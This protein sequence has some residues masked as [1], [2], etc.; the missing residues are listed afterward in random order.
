MLAKTLVSSLAM[1]AV[2]ACTDTGSS[3]DSL[4]RIDSEIAI[5]PRG[6]TCAQLGLGNQSLTLTNPVTGTYALDAQNSLNFTYYDDTNTIF[7]F[8]N[9]TIR[10]TGVLASIGDRTLMWELGVPGADG[11]GSLH[12]PPDADTGEIDTPEEVSFCFD[13]ELYVQPS[14]FAKHA[15]RNTWTITKSG[16]TERLVLAQGQEELVEYA[17]T[18]R[19]GESIEDGQ[20]I[21]GPMFVQ[22]K[23]PNTVTVGSVSVMVGTIAAGVTCPTAAPFT[24]AP[25]TIVE[26]AFRADVP[27]TT[28]RNVVGSA[29]V[30]HGLRVSTQEVVASFSSPTTGVD[31]VDHCVDVFD[32]AV[33]YADHYLGTVC[34]DTGEE[35]FEYSIEVGPYTTCGPFQVTNTASYV[36]LDTGATADAAWTIDGNV[37]CNAACTLTQRYWKVHSN[38]GHRRFNPTWNRI[39]AQGENTTFFH[40]GGTY[41]QAMYRFALGNPYWT[42]SKAYIAA[43]LNQLNGATFTPATQTAFTNATTLLNSYTPAQVFLNLSVRK[44]FVKAAATLKD[45]NSGRTGPGRCTTKPDLDSED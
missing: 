27:D 24:M 6:S 4:G 23:S 2:A 19:P 33:P 13:Y 44:Q 7:Y 8:N 5:I 14:P 35:T 43:R 3:W 9:S 41:V 37:Q 12:G 22:N 21:A 29:T 17:V 31:E 34:V 15:E 39:G 40:S 42:M 28:D 10:I 32:D 45:F 11:W 1:L 20:F 18:V 25:F 26:C 38:F 16:R 36:G 30:S